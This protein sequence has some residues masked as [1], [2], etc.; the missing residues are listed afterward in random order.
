MPYPAAR[1]NPESTPCV[2]KM[3]GSSVGVREAAKK[4]C[5]EESAAGRE[6]MPKPSPHTPPR[7][8]IWG[9]SQIHWQLGARDLVAQAYRG[10][11]VKR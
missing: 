7:L 11:F 4:Q 6:R 5:S 9:E 2:K 8:S 10:F 1:E 3:R